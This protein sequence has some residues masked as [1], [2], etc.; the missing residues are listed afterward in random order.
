[1]EQGCS[2]SS[3]IASYLALEYP[4]AEAVHLA[5]NYLHKAILN[6]CEYRL[7]HGHGPVH[8]FINGGRNRPGRY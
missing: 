3:A 4:L 6:G 1:M 7:G 8:H 5:E 2:L